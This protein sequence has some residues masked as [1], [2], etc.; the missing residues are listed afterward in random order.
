MSE[1]KSNPQLFNILKHKNIVKVRSKTPGYSLCLYQWDYANENYQVYSA[2]YFD[3]L[4]AAQDE[5]QRYIN[6]FANATE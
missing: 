3:T 6:L 1:I 5:E 2:D 4:E